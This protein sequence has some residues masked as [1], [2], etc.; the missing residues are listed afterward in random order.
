MRACP[1]SNDVFV[2]RDTG[3]INLT[4]RWGLGMRILE[5]TA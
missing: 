2:D 1:Q 3:L 5:R 4:V